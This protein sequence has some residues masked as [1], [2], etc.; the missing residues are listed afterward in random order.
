MPEALSFVLPSQEQLKWSSALGTRYIF[1]TAGSEG[2]QRLLVWV[3]MPTKKITHLFSSREN[4]E[5][6]AYF[7]N[8]FFFH[9]GLNLNRCQLPSLLHPS[10]TCSWVAVSCLQC[11]SNCLHTTFVPPALCRGTIWSVG[12][13]LL[14]M[15][16][17]RAV[18]WLSSGCLSW[19][20]FLAY[21]HYIPRR[22]Y[23]LF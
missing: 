13:K 3:H 22:T 21:V 17:T 10:H 5:F 4:A 11:L 19:K 8:T 15:R 20:L 18:L 1:L 12:S 2:A 14:Q 7:W 16:C 6:Q 23:S 9:S